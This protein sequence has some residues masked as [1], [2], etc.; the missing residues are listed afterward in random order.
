MDNLFFLFE[1]D[2]SL[3]CIQVYLDFNQNYNLV[4]I[5]KNKKNCIFLIK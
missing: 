4:L 2:L 3:D 5:E 1:F